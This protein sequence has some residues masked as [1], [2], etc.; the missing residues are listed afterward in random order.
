MCA[1]TPS[2]SGGRSSQYF[3][4]QW[5]TL[6]YL[7]FQERL[8]DFQSDSG[9][10]TCALLLIILSRH[11]S[12]PTGFLVSGS[13]ESTDPG[14]VA[15]GP[16]RDPGWMW[17]VPDHPGKPVEELDTEYLLPKPRASVMMANP[18]FPLLTLRAAGA[19]GHL[20]GLLKAARPG[21]AVLGCSPS[22]AQ[23]A[24]ASAPPAQG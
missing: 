4:W 2:T 7:S 14:K 18:S 20:S 24:H 12:D 21:K 1:P 10:L 22:P 6:L 5:R 15:A 11:G 16:L 3:A 13:P 8:G 17:L 23:I 9:S 19:E